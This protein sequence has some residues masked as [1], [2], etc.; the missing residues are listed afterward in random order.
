MTLGAAAAAGA[1]SSA[2]ML[3]RM[4]RRRAA[5]GL[6]GR[7][8]SSMAA[9]QPC[10]R[11]TRAHARPRAAAYFRGS[12]RWAIQ[13]GGEGPARLG[14]LPPPLSLGCARVRGAQPRVHYLPT[15]SSP[16]PS[17]SSCYRSVL[18]V[19]AARCAAWHVIMS[20]GSCLGP[21]NRRRRPA[22]CAPG[23][24]AAAGRGCCWEALLLQQLQPQH[25]C[26]PVR[27]GWLAG[28]WALH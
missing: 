3:Q 21:R 4:H 9:S 16:S 27:Y 15:S 24:A 1:G 28:E 6:G 7:C 10:A 13:S 14:P 22:G 11:H 23:G 17:S 5:C 2:A 20:C 8:S 25:L 12:G 18:C 26:M 19:G